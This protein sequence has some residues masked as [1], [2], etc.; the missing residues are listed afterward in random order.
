[1]YKGVYIRD[2]LQN[3]TSPV[4]IKVPKN[5]EISHAREGFYAELHLLKTLSNTGFVPKLLGKKHK[6]IRSVFK[7]H[8]FDQLTE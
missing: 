7:L 2:K 4:A 3:I 8:V 6:S 5:W 1:M